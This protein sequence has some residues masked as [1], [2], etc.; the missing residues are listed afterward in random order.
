[1]GV[2]ET[3][4]TDCN[5]ESVLPGCHETLLKHGALPAEPFHT[6]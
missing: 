5:L 3:M 6:F 1:M 2:A 4:L